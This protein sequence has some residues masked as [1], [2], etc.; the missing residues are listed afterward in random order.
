MKIQ[1]ALYR[2][3]QKGG[4]SDSVRNIKDV[5]YGEGGQ[6]TEAV[7]RQ[8]YSVILLDEFEKARGNLNNILLQILDEGHLTD[9]HGVRVSFKNCIVVL[10]TNIGSS[11]IDRQTR[12]VG[13]GTNMNQEEQDESEYNVLKEKT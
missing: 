12:S 13:F 7:R 11:L 10:T 3:I 9:S 5:G 1:S 6:L 4:S 8:P 2:N